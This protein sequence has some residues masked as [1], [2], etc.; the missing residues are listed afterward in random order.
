MS[1]ASEIKSTGTSYNDL[2]GELVEG[3]ATKPTE[4][5]QTSEGAASA[6]IRD[7]RERKQTKIGREYRK[8]LLEKKQKACNS[9]LQKHLDKIRELLKRDESPWVSLQLAR[10]DLD[11]IKDECNDTY[12]ELYGYLDTEE[13]KQALYQRFDIQGRAAMELRIQL[14]DQIYLSE[15]EVKLPEDRSVQ[16]GESRNTKRSKK[17]NTSGGSAMSRR[18]EAAARKAKLE[19]EKQF[20]DQEH[21]MRRL[22]LMKE[23]SIAQAEENAMKTILNEESEANTAGRASR[24]PLIDAAVRDNEI[25]DKIKY[26]D[27]KTEISRQL[28]E[29]ED[30]QINSEHNPNSQPFVPKQMSAI[31]VSQN[32]PRPSTDIGIA[33]DHLVSL[34]AKQTE[35]SSLLVNQ[36][37]AAYLPVKEPPVFSG[38]SFEYPAFVTAFDSIIGNNVHTE[39]DWLFF[40]EKYTSG[41][42]NEA[43]KGFLATNSDTAYK[44]ARK[45]LD[46]RYGNPVIVAENYK[47]NLRNWRHINDG[48]S[49]GLREFSDF[50][51]RCQ[52]AMKTVKS[53]AELDSSQILVTLSAKLPSYSGVK[54]CRFAHEEQTKHQKPI[55]FKDFV[56]F[57]KEE[58]EA[59]NDPVSSPDALKRERNKSN[60]ASEQRGRVARPRRQNNANTSQ[61][62]FSSVKKAKEVGQTVIP[63]PQRAFCP[64]C[65]GNHSV[66]KCHGIVNA[67]P[68]ERYDIFSSKGLCFKCAKPGH[69]ARD[70]Q[71][72][73]TCG[74]CGKKH[75]TLLHRNEPIG[76]DSK[77]HPKQ[78]PSQDGTQERGENTPNTSAT[79]NA[80]SGSLT[81][82][83]ES[84][85]ITNSKLVPFYMSHRDHPKKEM[86]V[87][88]LLDDASDTTFVTTKVQEVLGLKGVDTELTLSTMSGKEVISVSRIDGLVAE[89]LDRRAKVELPK[90]YTRESIPCRENQIPTP[91]MADRWSHL[92]KIKDKIP[93]LEADIEIGL[94][95]GCNCPKAIKPK[96]IITGRS[97]DPY[98]VRTLLGWCIVGPVSTTQSPDSSVF[99]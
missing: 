77:P 95:I 11:K 8:E 80:S 96:E 89:R 71:F 35:L 13:E 7:T 14:V 81:S 45:L 67:S 60:I 41:S 44:E 78:K 42:A 24:K 18:L 1:N 25:K 98:A 2:V 87:Y 93:K 53:M 43:I 37:R 12:H 79:A 83:V 40:L 4:E 21:E 47:S 64:I 9:K 85:V 36:Q 16:S 86:K 38:D 23:I 58:A 94:L 3:N 75:H 5:Y 26:E 39:K 27:I 59:A 63:P 33:L 49:K 91:E 99:S 88:A 46:Q 31:G 76:K 6:G 34:Q 92:K 20:L 65:E 17:S 51:I 57:V 15:R 66:V 74:E 22:Q 29:Q 62:F 54:W 72:K 10:D 90:S 82:H 68:I 73:P 48:D 69:L 97:E 70:C 19:V 55:G 50:L 32:Q 28:S 56:Q 52:E 30:K 61:S 84:A